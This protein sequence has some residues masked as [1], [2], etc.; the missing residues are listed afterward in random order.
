MA[1]GDTKAIRLFLIGLMAGTL[2]LPACRAGKEEEESEAEH[3]VTVDVAPA[4][5]TSIDLKVGAEAVL[6]PLRQVAIV[7]KITA[8]IRKFYV[9]RGAAVREGQLL[10][11]LENQDLAAAVAENQ[12]AYDQA[13]AAYQLSSRG[14]VPQEVERA[15]LEVKAAQDAL[16]AQQKRYDNLQELHEQGAI[17]QRDVNEAMVAL[18]QARNQLQIATRVLQDLRG[19][20]RDQNLKVAAAQ[21]DAALRR[22]EASQVQLGYSK[23]TSP[24]DGVV[25]D[26][27][28]FAG[29]TAAS[30]SPILTVMDLSSVIA[31]AHV[32]Q[33]DASQIK[34]G[35][36]ASL[37]TPDGER[38]TSGRVTQ[39]SPALDP[40]NTTVEIWV[41]A[42]NPGRRLKAGTSMRVEIVARSVPR[43]VVVPES[44]IVTEESGASLVMIVVE[45]NKA[46]RQPVRLGIR[47]AG[48]VQ[49]TEGLNDGDRVVSTGAFELA[50]LE[51]AILERTTLRTE[52]P[53]EKEK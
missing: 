23:I 39:I 30:G 24:I 22:L 53:K 8:P 13:E 35:N 18:T 3:I 44:A 11:E 52:P 10:A 32:S 31:R 15:E 21:R 9:D 20:G 27:P 50:K 19:F 41:Q 49:I 34:L 46:K 48:K 47:D 33:Q 40:A 38:V 28:L 12:A 4:M 42:S 17:S 36:T 14:T 2:V 45:G 43:A 1:P 16:N 37:L 7:P 6:Y 25:T 5:T 26:R 29:E 51:P